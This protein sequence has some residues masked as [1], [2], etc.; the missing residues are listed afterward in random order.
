MRSNISKATF[1]LLKNLILLSYLCTFISTNIAFKLV[2]V[3][4]TFL[5]KYAN[6]FV[7]ESANNEEFY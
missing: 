5:S 4:F 2:F 6:S 1:V 3:Y 7:F